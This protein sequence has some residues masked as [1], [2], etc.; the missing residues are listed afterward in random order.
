MVAVGSSVTQSFLEKQNQWSTSSSISISV[1]HCTCVYRYK[2]MCV[3]VSRNY[4]EYIVCAQLLSRV[5]LL[6]IINFRVSLLYLSV[7]SHLRIQ[8]TVD[9]VVCIYWKQGNPRPLQLNP[10][11]QTVSCV[12]LAGNPL[13][14]EFWN[15]WA[16]VTQTTAFSQTFCKTPLV[17]DFHKFLRMPGIQGIVTP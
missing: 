2:H 5:W 16:I 4:V 12:L 13:I 15:K 17:W 11:G 10:C 1:S 14:S 8:P 3:C 9:H 6:Y 7:L